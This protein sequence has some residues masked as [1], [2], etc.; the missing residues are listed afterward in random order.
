MA[1]ASM[2]VQI[3]EKDLE[4][5]LSR[6][7]ARARDMRPAMKDIGE[8]MLGVTDE[9]FSAEEDPSGRP[10][11]PHSPLTLMIAYGWTRRKKD[12]ST[13]RRKLYTQK[14]GLTSGFERYA[15]NR[16]ILTLS[17]RLR[18]SIHYQATEDSV[19]I[20]TDAVYAAIHQFGGKAGRG[21]K[22]SIPARPYLGISDA[23]RSEAVRIIK[24]HLRSMIDAG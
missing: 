19:V 15:M 24:E 6:I 5:K 8:Y 21:R 11:Q 16:K 23:D 9:R 12:G 10:W 1:G 7:M 20:G 17:S 3:N 4:T 14:G 2:H 13:S 22:V 18:K